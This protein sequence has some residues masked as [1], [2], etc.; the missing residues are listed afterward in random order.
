MES[1]GNERKRDERL[2]GQTGFIS[3]HLLL[4]KTGF[5]NNPTS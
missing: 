5:A 2:I 3:K 4:Q 1:G